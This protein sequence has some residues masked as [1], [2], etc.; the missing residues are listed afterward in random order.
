MIKEAASYV[1]LSTLAS[2][3]IDS[4][5]GGKLGAFRRTILMMMRASEGELNLM[6][7]VNRCA[8]SDGF[9]VLQRGYELCSAARVA[10][11]ESAGDQPV[12]P[13]DRPVQGP[14]RWAA[15]SRSDNGGR[16][17]ELIQRG[18]ALG[19]EVL[20]RVKQPAASMSEPSPSPVLSP[21]TLGRT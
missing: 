17:A 8:G 19:G 3:I 16:M 6:R 12:P 4:H 20:A 18:A 2:S 15:R 11:L 1:P 14:Q 21:S 7:S 5:A 9:A 13:G 10:R